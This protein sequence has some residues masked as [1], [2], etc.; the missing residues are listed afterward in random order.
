MAAGRAHGSARPCGHGR[1]FAMDYEQAIAFIEGASG[2]GDKRGL[3]NMERLLARLGDPH[4]RLRAFHVAGTNGKGSICAFLESALRAAGYRTGLYTSPHLERF[5]DR[6][7]LCGRP[8]AD[9]R[10]AEVTGRVAVEVEALR[11][12]GVRPTFFEICTAVAFEFFAEEEVD[13]AVIEVGLGGERDSTNVITPMVS[14]IASIGYDHMKTLGNT[15]E[16]I[17]AAKAGIV[18]PGVPVVLSPQPEQVREVIARRCREQGSDLFDLTKSAMQMIFEDERG[19]EFSFRLGDIDWPR[20][21]IGLPG[22]HQAHNAACAL[23]AL[24][25]AR[26][27]AGLRLNDDAIARGLKEARWPGRLEWIE[28]SPRVLLDGAHNGPGARTLREYARRHLMGRRVVLL[29]AM[30]GDKPVEDVVRQL[31]GITSTAVVTLIDSPRAL[32]PKRLAVLLEA[33]SVACRI[34]PD[35]E[36]ALAAARALAGPEG[37]VLISGSLYL[38][39]EMRDM[40]AVGDGGALRAD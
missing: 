18:K 29:T 23:T 24:E 32:E 37:V 30:L 26:R 34:E 35:R 17:A 20:I 16:E 13:Y 11:A 5:N 40:L 28:G 36:R 21:A 19:G 6:M 39:G 22:A 10:L 38:V 15:L 33:N 9:E 14:V 7:R 31:A 8:I 4:R 1:F 2:K 27:G 12:E 3:Y 25:L